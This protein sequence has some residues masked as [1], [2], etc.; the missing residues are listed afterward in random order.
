MNDSMTDFELA[1]MAVSPTMRGKGIGYL[2]GN[3]IIKKAQSIGATSL[4]LESNTILESAIYLYKKL[5]FVEVERRATPYK[6]CNIQ[7]KLVL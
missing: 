3:A 5:G 2:L 7:M 1:K 4:Y 6:R